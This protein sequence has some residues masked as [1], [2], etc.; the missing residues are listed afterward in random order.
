MTSRLRVPVAGSA[1]DPTVLRLRP[2]LHS[3]VHLIR[4]AWHIDGRAPANLRSEESNINS[5]WSGFSMFIETPAFG[6]ELDKAN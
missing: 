5:V 4:Y 6:E 3:I 2:H 1:F